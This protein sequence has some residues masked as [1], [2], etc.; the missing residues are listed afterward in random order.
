MGRLTRAIISLSGGL[1]SAT[2]LGHA[3]SQ[4]WQCVA[5]TFKYPSKHNPWERDAAKRIAD[6]YKVDVMCVDLTSLFDSFK[7]D[8]LTS[9][10]EIPEGHY[11]D[12]TMRATVVPCRNMIFASV[13]A[14]LAQS[15]NCHSIFLGVHQG[16]HYIYPDCR[17]SFIQSMDDAISHATEG[18]VTLRTPFLDDTKSDIVK[19]GLRLKV[20]YHLTRTCYKAQGIACGKCGS[21]RERLEAFAKNNAKDPI[22][23]EQA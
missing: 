19:R 12:D 6:H 23:Y 21:C 5:Y 7:S 4:D 2:L 14:G 1:D 15:Q 16:D 18:L 9:G 20:P 3:I 17:P 11:N 22:T 13:L 10:G 8:L